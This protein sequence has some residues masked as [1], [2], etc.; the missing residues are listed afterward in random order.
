MPVSLPLDLERISFLF[1]PIVAYGLPLTSFFI[2]VVIADKMGLY[3]QEER[4]SLYLAS[5]PTNLVTTGI[6]IQNST[7]QKDSF[8]T[9]IYMESGH[10]FMLFCGIL[11]FYGTVSFELFHVYRQKLKKPPVVS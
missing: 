5:I 1:Y 9:Q 10:Q 4:K 8:N 7:Y 3:P 2:G 6:L 11:I